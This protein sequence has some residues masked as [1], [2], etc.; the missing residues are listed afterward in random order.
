[1]IF[2]NIPLYLCSDYR[3]EGPVF[4]FYRDMILSIYAIFLFF[5]LCNISNLSF[6]LKNT[7]EALAWVHFLATFS[8]VEPGCTAGEGGSGPPSH[9][10]PQDCVKPTLQDRVGKS[11]VLGRGLEG[12]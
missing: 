9:L 5:F 12:T 3:H 6:P 11:H 2:I 10:S 8:C 7:L 4:L 1:M